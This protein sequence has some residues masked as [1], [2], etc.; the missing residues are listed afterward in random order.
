M[1]QRTKYLD[2]SIAM[3][4]YSNRHREYHRKN[5]PAVLYY[6]QNKKVKSESWYINGN[7]HRL[8]G[9][10]IIYYN[11]NKIIKEFYYID[12]KMYSE[13]KYW[14]KVGELYE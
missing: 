8:D 11:E 12:N 14:V 10:S 9:P 4:A 2:G 1:R 13:L 7:L 3:V 5:K 6:Y